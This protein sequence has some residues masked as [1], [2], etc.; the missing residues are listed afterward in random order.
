MHPAS[1]KKKGALQKATRGSYRGSTKFP[2]I[3]GKDK[4]PVKSVVKSTLPSVIKKS[5]VV[6]SNKKQKSVAIKS[7][8]DDF[9]IRK[10]ANI[11]EINKQFLKPVKDTR[12]SY[13]MS[14]LRPKPKNE[15]L[16][17]TVRMVKYGIFSLLIISSLI[18]FIYFILYMRDYFQDNNSL[19]EKKLLKMSII[20]SALIFGIN[21]ILLVLLNA[22]WQI[23]DSFSIP[24]SI[25]LR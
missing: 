15:R 22:Y 14:F 19:E 4:T 16:S 1:H 6:P 23:F 7:K 5:V 12:R 2:F 8:T 13:Y 21:M 9:L 24:L 18:S 11:S 3:K 10:P 20:G 17:S 25:A